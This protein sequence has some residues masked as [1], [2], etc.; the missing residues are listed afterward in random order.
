M[1]SEPKFRRQKGAK[2]NK[3]MKKIGHKQLE[4]I[5]SDL[6]QF[7]GT[8]NLKHVVSKQMLKIPSS[9]TFYQLFTQMYKMLYENH[10]E[11]DTFTSE[12]TQNFFKKLGKPK[13]K[14]LIF[15]PKC[16]GLKNLG[17][18]LMFL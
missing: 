3:D 9:N 5:I 16:L 12:Q 10:D 7:M 17:I 8:H 11:N 2:K 1:S 15:S 13:N 6:Y 18:I 14:P 4:K